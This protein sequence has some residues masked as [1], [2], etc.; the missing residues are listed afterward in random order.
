L[1]RGTETLP[2]VQQLFDE[3]HFRGLPFRL[4][5]NNSMA[6]P[7]MYV[8]RLAGM[9]IRADPDSIL[10]SAGA[11]RQYL[12]DT[13][14]SRAR[15]HVLG[16][17]ALTDQ[18]VSKGDFEIVD[19]DCETPDAVVVGLDREVTYDKLR[20]AHRGIQS[21]AQFIATNGDVTLPTEDGLV[22]GCGS[23]IAA[24]VASTGRHPTVIG[25]PEVHLLEAAVTDMKV[26]RQTCVMVGDR[27]DTDIAAGH[28]SGML[29]VMVLTG[30]S[31]RDDIV[32]APVKPDLVF[33]DL[34]AI[35]ETIVNEG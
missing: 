15:L 27:L 7:E 16:A 22:P 28:R 20:K 14:G 13:L 31:T 25:K 6:S 9:G 12:S 11:T 33:T 21:G 4:A 26:G 30:V 18:L 34:P 29:T 5:T 32:S 2:G 24:L 17:P 1:Y 8:N 19:P 3:L 23:L 35:L 10:T